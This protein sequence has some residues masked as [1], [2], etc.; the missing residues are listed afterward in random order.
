MCFSLPHIRNRN[1]RQASDAPLRDAQMC[2]SARKRCFPTASLP[3]SYPSTHRDA[4]SLS[5][6]LSFSPLASLRLVRALRRRSAVVK[7]NR[8]QGAKKQTKCSQER[9]NATFVPRDGKRVARRRSLRSLLFDLKS[10]PSRS[11]LPPTKHTRKKKRKRY[12]RHMMQA[13]LPPSPL[14]D[15]AQCATPREQ[16]RGGQ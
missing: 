16:R 2:Y 15:L 8:S 13:P 6:S 14:V 7:M 10:A 1:D 4:Y 12:K 5:L 11:R 3:A 9:L